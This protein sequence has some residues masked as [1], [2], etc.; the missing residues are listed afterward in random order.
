M[1]VKATR[2]DDIDVD[3]LPPGAFEFYDTATRKDAGM[4]YVCPCGCGR[5]GALNFRE[6]ADVW[7]GILPAPDPSWVW[8]GNREAPTLFPSVHDNPGETTHWHGWLKAGV[9]ESC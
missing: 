6:S 1:R 8:D 4:I 2:V 9:W 7:D 5:T 3:G